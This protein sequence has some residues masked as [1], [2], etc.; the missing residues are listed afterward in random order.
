[1]LQYNIQK[2]TVIDKTLYFL[3]QSSIQYIL[4]LN[5]ESAE[6]LNIQCKWAKSHS[7]FLNI[8][9]TIR[10]NFQFCFVKFIWNFTNEQQHS[11]TTI[12]KVTDKNHL[13]FMGLLTHSKIQ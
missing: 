7:K 6:N 10:L 4:Q 8:L 2:D 1:M 5:L 12:N 9:L 13:K 11:C 3:M